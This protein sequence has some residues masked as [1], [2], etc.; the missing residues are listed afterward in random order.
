MTN[1]L[2]RLRALRVQGLEKARSVLRT[3]SGDASRKASSAYQGLK[4]S[5]TRK[6]AANK[7]A[8]KLGEFSQSDTAK[9]AASKLSDLK[10]SDTAKKAATKLNELKDTDTA[11]KAAEKLSDL[12]ETDTAHK[13]V[14]ALQDLRQ[15]DRVRKAEESARRTFK[16][17][18]TSAHAGRAAASGNDNGDASG[19]SAPGAGSTTGAAPASD[20]TR[21]DQQ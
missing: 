6:Q 5:E 12:K 13:A 21:P 4:D 7:A 3:R 2:E 19:T 1:L 15:R 20:A 17:L 18:F 16:D 10:E 9:K 8:A 14:T 11:K